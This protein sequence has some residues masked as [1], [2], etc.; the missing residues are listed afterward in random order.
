MLVY[1][2]LIVSILFLLQPDI[3]DLLARVQRQMNMTRI[4]KP[5]LEET[6]MC[7]LKRNRCGFLSVLNFLGN[8][9]VRYCDRE[10]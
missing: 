3:Q 9:G 5:R 8:N 4:A 7:L 10:W 2:E 1:K 6:E